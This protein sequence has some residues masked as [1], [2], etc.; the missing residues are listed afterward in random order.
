MRIGEGISF[1]H[2]LKSSA[3]L[4]YIAVDYGKEEKAR[5]GAQ[6]PK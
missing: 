2:D 6:D 1:E 4:E 3:G 5:P